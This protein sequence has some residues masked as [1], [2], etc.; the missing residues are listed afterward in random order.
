[1]GVAARVRRR[2]TRVTRVGEM[3]F[4]IGLVGMYVDGAEGYR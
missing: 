4:W 1:M 3:H 2:V